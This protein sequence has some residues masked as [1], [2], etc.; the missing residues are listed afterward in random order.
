MTGA[1]WWYWYHKKWVADRCSGTVTQS[2]DTFSC[3]DSGSNT[4]YTCTT[5][6]VLVFDTSSPVNFT[7]D[8]GKSNFNLAAAGEKKAARTDWPTAVTPWLAL[9][10]DND[11]AITSGEELFGSATPLGSK[12]AANGFEALAALDDNHDGKI[13]SADVAFDKLRLWADANA[14]RVSASEELQPLAKRGVYSISLDFRSDSRCDE[15]GNCEVERATFKW[16][17]ADGKEHQGEVVDVHLVARS[18]GEPSK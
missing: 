17:D 6:L 13:D 10:R 16:R 3:F 5:P 9:D 8:D 4:K 11:G 1:Q 7:P 14:D 12:T 2:G 15:R 18:V